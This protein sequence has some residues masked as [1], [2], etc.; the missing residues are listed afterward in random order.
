M[1][2]SFFT[3][4]NLTSQ[5][6]V[7]WVRSLTAGGPVIVISCPRDF[8]AMKSKNVSCEKSVS[9]GR[10]LLSAKQHGA[11]SP[12]DS[13]S[14]REKPSLMGQCWL[15]VVVSCLFVCCLFVYLLFLLFVVCVV[16]ELASLNWKVTV[17]VTLNRNL[18]N[19]NIKIFLT[20]H[21]I[22]LTYLVATFQPELN[23]NY[24]LP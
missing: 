24:T 23:S 7:W 22:N 16:W 14:D 18:A 20:N 12:L 11:Q 6:Q 1:L 19:K 9:W 17:N 13:L 21:W 4:Y 3:A 5:T 8:P 2:L 15:F 10:D